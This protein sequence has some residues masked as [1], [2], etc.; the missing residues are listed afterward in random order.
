MIRLMW[1]LGLVLLLGG[2]AHSAGVVRLYLTASVP[3]ANRVLLDVWIAQAQMLSGALYLVAARHARTGRPWRSLAVFGALTIIGFTG[4]MLPVLFHRAQVIFR[5][6]LIVYSLL[7]A[8][9][10]VST[11]GLPGTP[12]KS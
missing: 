4:A 12:L 11:L 5:L 6:P 10:L 2:I 8:S 3:E 1:G 9:I 7:S